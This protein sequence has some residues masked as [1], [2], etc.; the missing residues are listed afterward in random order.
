MALRDTALHCIAWHC[1]A[2]RGS[3]TALRC[4]ALR[5]VARRRW[6]VNGCAMV[7]PPGHAIAIQWSCACDF[8]GH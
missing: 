2:L 5:C 6:P 4:T 1:V 8:K 3:C 7:L